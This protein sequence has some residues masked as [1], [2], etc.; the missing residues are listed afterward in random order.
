MPR[1]RV[2][3]TRCGDRWTEARFWSFI[4]SL[5][6]SGFR[7]WAVK[8]DVLKAARRQKKGHK[9]FEYVCNHC[10]RWFPNSGVEVDHIIPAGSLKKYEDLHGFVLRLF[11]EEEGLQVLCKACHLVKTNNERTKREAK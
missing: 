11:P 4:R 3:R 6:R 1:Q 5:L 2:P 8:Q 10:K 9:R 7:K